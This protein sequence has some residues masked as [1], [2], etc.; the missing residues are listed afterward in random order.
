MSKLNKAIE[1]V[2]AARI[3]DEKREKEKEMDE[4]F[5]SLTIFQRSDV[6]YSLWDSLSFED[7]KEEYGAE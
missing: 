7:K 1:E 5:N 2:K 4:W 3:A 6:A